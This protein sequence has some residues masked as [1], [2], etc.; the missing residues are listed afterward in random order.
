MMR[1]NI[2]K[3]KFGMSVILCS[4]MSDIG[5]AGEVRSVLNENPLFRISLNNDELEFISCSKKGGNE[6][7]SEPV[8]LSKKSMLEFAAAHLAQYEKIDSYANYFDN[9]QRVLMSTSVCRKN[10]REGKINNVPCFEAGLFYLNYVHLSGHTYRWYNMN[11]TDDLP[12]SKLSDEQIAD[13]LWHRLQSFAA[14]DFVEYFMGGPDLTDFNTRDMIT[15]QPILD[16]IAFAKGRPQDI[17][18]QLKEFLDF[19]KYQSELLTCDDNQSKMKLFGTVSD[20]NIV[21]NSEVDGI[22]R[23]RY[24]IVLDEC[25]TTGRNLSTDLYNRLSFEGLPI[26][27]ALNEGS[28]ANCER[29]LIQI[30][31]VTLLLESNKKESLDSSV[32]KETQSTIAKVVDFK[33]FD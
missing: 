2:C 17:A 16:A 13:M 30:D 12:L 7:C 32:E 19:D 14:D 28:F 24:Q 9:L 33:C 31:D 25:N 15:V 29:A 11:L 4:L 18:K 10:G 26:Q 20:V 23:G 5:S 21:A 8:N 22:F 3:I 1:L 27:S 6:S